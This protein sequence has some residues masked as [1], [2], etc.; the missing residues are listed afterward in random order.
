MYLDQPV[1]DD[2]LRNSG[3]ERGNGTKLQDFC[4]YWHYGRGDDVD[5]L[6]RGRHEL[7]ASSEPFT[8]ALTDPY[9]DKFRH[10][11]I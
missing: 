1:R 3:T 9:A 2:L 7:N 11:R 6:W 10:G 4:R 5:R 8:N